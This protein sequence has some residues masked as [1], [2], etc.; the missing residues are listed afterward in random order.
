MPL[1][2]AVHYPTTLLRATMPPSTL[3]CL[4]RTQLPKSTISPFKRPLSTP[5]SPTTKRA[6][7]AFY[8][9]NKAR[10]RLDIAASKLLQQPSRGP[11]SETEKI[12]L[13]SEEVVRLSKLLGD[14]G[15]KIA[16]LQDQSS[17]TMKLL[18]FIQGLGT[19]IGWVASVTTI[20]VGSGFFELMNRVKITIS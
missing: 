14:M 5:S 18:E 2:R 8:Y 3:H 15:A 13:L 4:S 12:K 7:I 11:V 1:L 6:A 9:P 20:M 17:S 19:G 10:E 16:K